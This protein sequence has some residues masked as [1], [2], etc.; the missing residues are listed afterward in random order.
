MFIR[1]RIMDYWE[2]VAA[3]LS[4]YWDRLVPASKTGKLSTDTTTCYSSP[5]PWLQEQWGQSLPTNSELKTAEGSV[6]RFDAGKQRVLLRDSPCWRNI[7]FMLVRLLHLCCVQ[8]MYNTRQYK[9]YVQ[10]TIAYEARL[11]IYRFTPSLY[12]DSGSSMSCI[13]TAAT[14]S[15]CVVWCWVFT[16][17][18]PLTWSVGTFQAVQ[19]AQ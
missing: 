12:Q 9:P 7:F 18:V 1:A 13:V 19:I 17:F 8:P 11:H 2:K 15:Y 4:M 5:Q 3:Y 16:V 6:S 14:F 10:E